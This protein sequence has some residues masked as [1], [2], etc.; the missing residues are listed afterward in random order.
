MSIDL[1][2]RRVTSSSY[3]IP[4]TRMGGL[5]LLPFLTAYCPF[6]ATWGSIDTLGA[7]QPYVAMADRLLPGTSTITTRSRYLSMLRAALAYAEKHRA[8]SSGSNGFT[9]RRRA[10]EPCE[11]IW[12]LACVAARGGGVEGAADGLRGV[13]ASERWYRHYAAN[14]EL[15]AT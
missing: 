15:S 3:Y 4:A 13:T 7:L 6:G 10:L 11:R 8:V 1:G 14:D 2:G 9:E 12:A 5:L